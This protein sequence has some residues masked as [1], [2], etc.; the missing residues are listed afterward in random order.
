MPIKVYIFGKEFFSQI[1]LWTQTFL[2]I[3]KNTF[4]PKF[5]LT[6]LKM[7]LCPKFICGNFAFWEPNGKHFNIFFSPKRF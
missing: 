1:H 5:D 7:Y 4:C 3:S 6:R 2:Q